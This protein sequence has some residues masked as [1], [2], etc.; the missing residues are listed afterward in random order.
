MTD[1]PQTWDERFTPMQDKFDNILLPISWSSEFVKV[2]T[3]GVDQM[4]MICPSERTDYVDNF[5]KNEEQLWATVESINKDLHLKKLQR[6]QNIF[7]SA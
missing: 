4:F 2:I 3:K 1:R 6:H 5:F 7:M